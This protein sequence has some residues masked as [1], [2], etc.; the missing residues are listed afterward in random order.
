MDFQEAI[1]T[2]QDELGIGTEDLAR[3]LEVEPDRL[4]RALRDRGAGEAGDPP[5]GWRKKLG[6]TLREHARSLVQ[7]D[8]GSRIGPDGSLPTYESSAALSRGE[9]RA[10]RLFSLARQIEWAGPLPLD[11]T[12]RANARDG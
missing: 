3:A 11:E 4:E 5:E 2:L 9:E 12:D 1:H 7:A 8:P 6:L 10:Q